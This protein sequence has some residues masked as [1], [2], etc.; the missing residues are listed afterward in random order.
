MSSSDG[1]GVYEYVPYDSRR[2]P[3]YPHLVPATSYQS[4]PGSP[5]YHHSPHFPYSVAPLMDGCVGSAGL[6]RHPSTATVKRTGSARSTEHHAAA[7]RASHYQQQVQSWSPVGVATSYSSYALPNNSVNGSLETSYSEYDDCEEQL[8]C[9]T[10]TVNYRGGSGRSFVQTAVE[11]FGSTAATTLTTTSVVTTT[12]MP[13]HTNNSHYQS[14]QQ[15]QQSQQQQQ[16]P[17]HQSQGQ[18][19]PTQVQSGSQPS[20]GHNVAGSANRGSG[21]QQTIVAAPSAHQAMYPSQ[22]IPAGYMSGGPHSNAVY[23]MQVIPQPLPGNVYVSNLTANVN[24]HGYMPHGM[25]SYMAAAGTPPGSTGA[26]IASEVPAGHEI[27]VLGSRGEAARGAIRRN[28][29][30]SR[31]GTTPRLRGAY[32]P[33]HITQQAVVQQGQPHQPQP[34]QQGQTQ[35][36]PQGIQQQQQQPAQGPSQ[37]QPQQPPQQHTPELMQH[38]M[39]MEHQQMMSPAQPYGYGGGYYFPLQFYQPHVGHPSAQHATGAPIFQVPM[40]SSPMYGYTPGVMYPSVYPPEYAVYVDKGDE[41]NPQQPPEEGVMHPEMWQPPTMLEYNPESGEYIPHEDDGA[42]MQPVQPTMQPMAHVLDPNVPNFTM[43]MGPPTPIQTEE[44]G[45]I[46][47]TPSEEYNVINNNEMMSPDANLMSSPSSNASSQQ[48]LTQSDLYLVPQQSQQEPHPQQMLPQHVQLIEISQETVI[49]HDQQQALIDHDNNYIIEEA[50]PLY[51]EPMTPSP[52]PPPQQPQPHHIHT[53]SEAPID[54]SCYNPAP[55]TQDQTPIPSLPA[56]IPEHTEILPQSQV[57]EHAPAPMTVA[58]PITAPMPTPTPTPVTPVVAPSPIPIPLPITITHVP[59]PQLNKPPPPIPIEFLKLDQRQK[60]QLQ[61][62]QQQ[63]Q[64][65]INDTNNNQKKRTNEVASV[66]TPATVSDKTSGSSD[67]SSSKPVPNQQGVTN[68]SKSQMTADE[69]AKLTRAVQEKFVLKDDRRSNAYRSTWSSHIPATTISSFTSSTTTV[70]QHNTQQKKATA[71]VSVSAIPNKEFSSISSTSSMSGPTKPYYKNTSPVPFT[72]LGTTSAPLSMHKPLLVPQK[73]FS[74]VESSSIVS[75]GPIM[76]SKKVE[77]IPHREMHNTPLPPPGPPPL[78]SVPP[79]Q[80]PYTSGPTSYAPPPVTTAAPPAMSWASLFNSSSSSNSATPAT[81]VVQPAV[82]AGPALPTPSPF[83]PSFIPH[84]QRNQSTSSPSQPMSMSGGASSMSGSSLSQPTLDAQSKKPIAK[85][86]PFD[87]NNSSGTSSSSTGMSY[88]TASVQGLPSTGAAS[89]SAANRD[90]N[91]QTKPEQLDENTLKLGEFLSAYQIENNSISI[92]PRGLINRSNYCYINAILQALVACPPFYHLMRAIRSL[93]AAKSSKHPKPFIDAM[94][95]LVAEF[96]TLTPRSKVQRDKSKKDETPEIHYDSPI[97][98]VVIHKILSLLRSDIFQVE[99]RQE[100]AE[101]FLG[102][103]L[104]RLND[105]MLEL[106]K[107]SKNESELNGNEDTTNGE[108]HGD[109]QDDWKVIRGNRNKGTVTRTTDF[110]RS[111]ISDIFGGK[112]R[113]RVHREGDHATDNIQP[114]FTLQLDIEKAA[115]VKDALDLLVGKDQ[116]E[117]VTCSKTKQEIAAWQQV[118]LEELPIV[119]ILHLKCF[120]YKLDGCT[121]ILKTLEFP[122]ELKIDSKLMSSKGK[123]YT[124]KQKQYKLFA[125]VYHDG[126]EASKGHYITDVFHAGYGSWIRYDDSTVKAVPEFNVLHP[127]APRVPYLL[128]YRR[129]DTHYHGGGG[130]SGSGS[131]SSSGTVPTS[132]NTAVGTPGYGGG[133]NGN[134]S[135]NSSNN[136]NSSSSLTSNYSSSGN[137][138]NSA[139]SG[140]GGSSAK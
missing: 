25:P 60:E 48:N 135:S 91:V 98:P 80:P 27:Q 115:S 31:I 17:Q 76:E 55:I 108:V 71:S 40:Y 24:V 96:S 94:T 30:S 50:Q 128:Y 4:Y 22:G 107:L 10:G 52:P 43:Q 140:Y 90:K 81:S 118:T 132:G 42:M 75:G 13:P 59:P 101:E 78:L 104:N 49:H 122:I 114:F 136:N 63:A 9:S 18:Q 32:I 5:E 113:S 97:E 99:G 44:Y 6:Y 19:Q 14:Q 116:L 20:N 53:Q 51:T 57:Q 77:A 45:S 65:I 100:D 126:K 79:P 119:M 69:L 35:V 66:A 117:G 7:G 38:Q 2:Y 123:T 137:S 73:S 28:G 39:A 112:L 37:Q 131:T 130:S 88:S 34:V 33:H 8:S 93:P 56:Q 138:Y 110:G 12:S 54:N 36:Q 11:S 62:Q 23:P 89:S 86:L 120:D 103:V 68:S 109:D 61:Q 15:Q 58:A 74:S 72:T 3:P 1:S 95:A 21:E 133:N 46:T 47:P 139:N 124:A 121:K 70:V 84:L 105:E 41:Q 87:K 16:Q 111:P 82:S 64:S 85:V 83:A 125:V 127:K 26:F 102:C 92:Q 129:L 67:M 106:M 29:R 134:N